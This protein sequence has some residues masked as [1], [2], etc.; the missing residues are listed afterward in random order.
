MAIEP[1]R[2]DLGGIRG[3]GI[4]KQEVTLIVD[5]PTE[6]FQTEYTVIMPRPMNEIRLRRQFT[7]GRCK[8]YNPAIAR[9]FKDEYGYHVEPELPV[10]PTRKKPANKG[11]RYVRT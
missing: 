4:V 2:T 7:R 6:E 8:V 10:E 5:E 11:R 1:Q 9:Q 3:F